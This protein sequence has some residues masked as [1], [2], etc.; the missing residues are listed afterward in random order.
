MM[1]KGYCI[2]ELILDNTYSWFNNKIVNYRISFLNPVSDE[3]NNFIDTEDYFF[4]DKEKW[5]TI[6]DHPLY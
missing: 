5:R 1:P 4:V 2:Y 6:I 3:E